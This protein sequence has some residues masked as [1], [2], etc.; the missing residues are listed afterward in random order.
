[1]KDIDT[2]ELNKIIRQKV[3]TKLLQDNE[4][5][6]LLATLIKSIVALIPDAVDAT[7]AELESED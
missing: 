7:I 4:Y 5:K 3:I 2:E 6:E 1:M